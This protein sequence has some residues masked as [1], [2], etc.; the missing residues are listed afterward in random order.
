SYQTKDGAN[1]LH[2]ASSFPHEEG[3]FYQLISKAKEAKLSDRD[4]FFLTPRD[5]ASD[6]SLVDNVIDVDRWVMKLAADGKIEELKE[7]LLEGYDYIMELQE[8]SGKSIIEIAAVNGQT[9]MVEFLQLAAAFEERRDF[10]HKAI[11][12]GS[13]AHVELLADSEDIVRAKDDRG[14]TSLHL[15]TLCEERPIMVLLSK[16]FPSL[17]TIGDN[18]SPSCSPC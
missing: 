9:K 18:V 2:F 11:K 3:V 5:I 17:L 4:K 12:V 1:I 6:S 16:A 8:E 14:R 10:L 15:A 7:L 13:L